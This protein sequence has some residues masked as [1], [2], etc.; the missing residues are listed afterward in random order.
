MHW[1]HLPIQI[2]KKLIDVYVVTFIRKKYKKK[3][4]EPDN[5]VIVF[6]AENDHIALQLQIPDSENDLYTVP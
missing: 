3:N 4:G 5:K 6:S 1:I 2:T